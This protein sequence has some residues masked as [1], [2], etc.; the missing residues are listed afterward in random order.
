MNPS[1]CR[2]CY[3]SL[4][5]QKAVSLAYLSLLLYT[6]QWGIQR[7]QVLYIYLIAHLFISIFLLNNY[8]DDFSSEEDYR[9]AKYLY[10]ID[11]LSIQPTL[12]VVRRTT[13]KLSIYIIDYP[14]I[15][16]TLQVVRRT[17]EKKIS[18]SQLQMIKV[19]PNRFPG[20]TNVKN[21][22]RAEENIRLEPLQIALIL[23]VT[24]TRSFQCIQSFA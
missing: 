2:F 1:F 9:E 11:C 6:W 7:R 5:V 13:E 24:S 16:P 23:V 4:A 20:N 18:N 15:K 19:Y 21:V 17:T 22:K 10:I 14:S 3:N 8:K 12:Q